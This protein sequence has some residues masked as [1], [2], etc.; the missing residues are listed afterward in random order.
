MSRAK[1]E[2]II[3]LDMLSTGAVFSRE[4][5]AVKEMKRRDFLKLARDTST[6]AVILGSV[7][8]TAPFLMKYAEVDLDRADYDASELQ[9]H[10]QRGNVSYVLKEA[11]RYFD[12]LEQAAF[13]AEMTRAAEV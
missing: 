1:C 4:I 2:R 10:F 7:G 3:R 13:P 9:G 5:Y 6:F 8:G 12:M 11:R